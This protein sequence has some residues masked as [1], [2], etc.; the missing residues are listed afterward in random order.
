MIEKLKEFRRKIARHD[1]SAW[2][3]LPVLLAVIVPSFLEP[4]WLWRL[5]ALV[6][7]SLTIILACI[8]AL[9]IPEQLKFPNVKKPRNKKIF[10]WVTYASGILAL[11]F[12]IYYFLI[13]SGKDLYR[14][15]Q[16]P[17]TALQSTTIEV[18]KWNGGGSV[19][20]FFIGQTLITSDKSYFLPFSFNAWGVGIFEVLYSPETNVIYEIEKIQ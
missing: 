8:H 15:I 14:V 7:A 10:F 16:N 18:T 13:P 6:V 4:E 2:E 5:L 19:A 9:S 3:A 11:L 12:I 17:T 20:P 1:I